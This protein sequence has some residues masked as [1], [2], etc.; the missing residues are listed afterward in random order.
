MSYELV[1]KTCKY[2][3]SHPEIWELIC[4]KK[5]QLFIS[6]LNQSVRVLF[7]AELCGRERWPSDPRTPGYNFECSLSLVSIGNSKLVN[8]ALV[9]LLLR[10]V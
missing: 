2:N 4:G 9:K 5:Q 10:N 7:F 6:L 3:Y 1:H 8:T